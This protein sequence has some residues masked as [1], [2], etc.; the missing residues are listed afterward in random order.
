[1]ILSPGEAHDCTAF[2]A[3][4]AERE[5]NPKVMLADKG[6]DTDDIR[7]ELR[8]RG[9]APESPSGKFCIMLRALLPVSAA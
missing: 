2:D 6:Y 9:A 8:A 7:G 3:L 1:M 4:M 5:A